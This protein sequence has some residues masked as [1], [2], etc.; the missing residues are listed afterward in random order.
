MF[1]HI[2]LRMLVLT[3]VVPLAIAPIHTLAAQSNE[4]D[5]LE[6]I[7]VTA[8]KRAENLQ[9]IPLAV[10]ALTAQELE[11]SALRTTFDLAQAAPNVQFQDVGS[12]QVFNIRGVTL[13]D[14][15]DAN[16]PPV[17]LYIDDVYQGTVGGH[18]AALF[19][20]ERV[21]ILR[22]P[23]GTLYGR[24]TTGGL[25]HLIA[26]PPERDFGGYIQFTAGSYSGR[27]IEGAV[28]G[29]LGER[30]AVRVS[31]RYDEDDGFQDNAVRGTNFGTTDRWAVRAQMSIDVAQDWTAV[32]RV[33]D[34]DSN[35][36]SPGYGFYGK[37]DPATGQPCSVDDILRSRC[38]DPRGFQVADPQPD[39][40][41]SDLSRLRNEL[42][43]RGASLRIDGRIAGADFTSIT[44]YDR[45]EKIFEEDAD[46]SGAA[47][48][49]ADYGA[50]ARQYSQELRIASP[51]ASLAWS[52]GAFYFHDE[53]EVFAGLPQLVALLGTTEGLAND[54]DINTESAAIYGELYVPLADR[55][56]W[57]LGARFTDEAKRLFISDD[58]TLPTFSERE[59]IDSSR[60]T[61]RTALDWRVNDHQFIYGSI[62]TGFKSGA[63]NTTFVVAGDAA[64]VGNETLTA[65]EIGSKN[66][67]WEDRLRWNAAVF[68][69]D[70][71][72][73]Q[74]VASFSQ[75]DVL[76]T[77]FIN[78][79]DAR[80]YG[81]E[82]ELAVRP[83]ERWEFG[84][85]V[86]YLDARYDAPPT[87][88]ISGRPIDGN[89]PQ[90]TPEYSA[91]AHVESRT[92][93]GSRGDVT[94]RLDYDWKDSV[95]FGPDNLPTERQS[96]VELLN[97]SVTWHSA[98][99]TWSATAAVENLTDEV[100]WVHSADLGNGLGSVQAVWGRPRNYGVRVGYSF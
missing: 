48:L 52:V 79:G 97:A 36:A 67:F 86:A 27:S 53:K 1:R 94:I 16:E 77:R 75:N 96:A 58:R 2:G 18:S 38:M 84:F 26:K 8:Q 73:I 54:A 43:T 92:P 14:I 59:R 17:G 20:L 88:T 10:T 9:N 6:T 3:G 72:G 51:P 98:S 32:L 65:Y 81:L 66:T 15:G 69:Y 93:L 40:T 47:L 87:T 42:E 23:Q 64:P 44:A 100:Y 46:G 49:L 76:R 50:D 35:G 82:S 34:S 24:N 95:F 68:Y 55:I 70:Y 56:R 30:A 13:I 29:P 62:S 31:A 25:V 78:A 99:L 85:N 7:T 12:V 60:T 11:S 74:T 37:L 61:W 45:Y 41:Y 5:V 89:R 33:H 19:D 80:I 22:G 39:V 90:L 71:Q 91:Q 21:E 4:H 83:S 63:F 57:T 28:G